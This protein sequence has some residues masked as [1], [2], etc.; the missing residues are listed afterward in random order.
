MKGTAERLKRDNFIEN[1]FRHNISFHSQINFTINKGYSQH[2]LPTLVK[3]NKQY[4]FIYVDASHRAD[5]TF[6][7]AYYAAR[8]LKKGGLL[9]FDDYAWK[10]PNNLHV[11]ESPQLGVDMF[12]NLYDKVFQVIHVGYQVFIVKKESL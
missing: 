8:M 2:I 6:V 1:N 10:D 5:D 4:D 7:D 9:I 12:C 3:Q 11:N